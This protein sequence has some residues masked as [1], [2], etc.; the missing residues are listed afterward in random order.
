MS[1]DFLIIGGG[2]AGT[3]AAAAL[4]K[5][6]TVHLL[7]RE[8]ALGYHASGRSA[9]L[10]EASY[11]L[12]ST[13][14]LNR[15]S[16]EGHQTADGGV[17]SPRGLMLIGRD[18]DAAAFEADQATMGMDPLTLGEAKALYPILDTTKVTRA[19]YD[20]KAWDIDTD[21]L[22]QHYARTARGNGAVTVNAEVTAIQRTTQGWEVSTRSGTHT[23]KHLVNAGGAWA[24]QIAILAGIT[25][26]GLTPLRRSMAR[27]PAPEGQDP[28]HW[29]MIFGPGEAWYSK[30][31]A[32][33]LLISP[34]DETPVEPHDA[35]AEDE[36]LATGI[37]RFQDHTTYEVTRLLSSWAGLRTFAPDRNLVLGPSPQDTTFI[38]SAGQGGYGFQTAP[39]ASQLLADLLSGKQSVL[40]LE[41]IAALSPARFAA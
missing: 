41:T 14:A 3:S 27:V 16:L 29:P 1:S 30:P 2:I 7:E 24:D 12:P 39:A 26:L 18:S 19:A 4:S 15:A 13:T 6:G 20:P 33:A 11:G 34:A 28:T 35:W 25:P 10:Y 31:D 21:R 37:A 32:G 22:I 8:S 40:D 38:W 5:L 17:L 36:T 23:A 9:A